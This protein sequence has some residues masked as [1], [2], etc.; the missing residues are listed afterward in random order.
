MNGELVSSWGWWWVRSTC[1]VL[2]WDQA[3]IRVSGVGI[4]D[5]SLFS[6]GCP[7]RLCVL[8]KLPNLCA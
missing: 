4:T 5:C 8:G 6:Q 7:A 3:G 2:C 1:G